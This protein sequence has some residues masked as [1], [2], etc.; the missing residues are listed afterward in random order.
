MVSLARILGACAIAVAAS[1]LAHPAVAHPAVAAA[2]VTVPFQVNP[3]PY[4]NPN[5]SFD[6]PPLQCA[7]RVGEAVGSV[8][9][10][11]GKP[12]GWGCLIY[13]QVDWLNLT[14]GASGTARM[15][16]GLN[17]FPPE[18]VLPT[19]G[20]QVALVL[21]PIPGTPTTPGFAAFHVP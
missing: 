1:A 17:G 2:S 14:T 8:T 6:V 15:S 9:V 10:T 16:D 4:G 12:A 18:A 21:H 11:G 19:G 5:G 3:A 7:V 20:G 13:A